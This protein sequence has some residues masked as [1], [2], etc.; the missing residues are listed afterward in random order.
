MR[1]IDDKMNTFN[2]FGKDG[3]FVMKLEGLGNGPGEF[4]APHSFWIDKHGYVFILDR[5]LSRL[6]KY[7]LADLEYVGD[8][9]LPAPSPLSFAV[10]PDQ[11]VYA[12]Y[13][14][15]RQDDV[16][17]GKQ[18]IVAGD[19][20]TVV[21]AFYDAPPSGKILHGCSS[22]FYLFDECIRAYP[23]FSNQVYE[24]SRDSF[25]CYYEFSW[26]RLA[27]PPIALFQKYENSGEVMKE[28]LTGENDWIRFLY[29]TKQLMY[30]L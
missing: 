12:Y 20:G 29:C 21:R 28:I 4:I 23:Y 6:L 17:S 13:Y 10:I 14:P 16:L 9:T 1:I 25:N 26:G 15:L 5:Q 19:D 3:K 2:V 8:V 11:E 24:L 7:R 30:W 27:F 22:N 18:F